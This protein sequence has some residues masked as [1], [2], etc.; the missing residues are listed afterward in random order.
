MLSIPLIIKETAGIDRLNEP[1]TC[2]I[3]LPRARMTQAAHCE[4]HDAHG[5]KTP[6]QTQ[7]LAHWPDGSVKWFLL[8]FQIS[9]PANETREVQVVVAEPVSN[10]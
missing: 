7:A 6:V 4:L 3:P 10:W 5:G 2:G 1:V 8:D 9:V